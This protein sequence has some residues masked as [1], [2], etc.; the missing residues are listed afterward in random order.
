MKKFIFILIALLS[1]S[2]I[3][4]ARTFALITA[5]SNYGDE[6]DTNATTNGAK[7]FQKILKT[8]TND[9][10]LLTSSNANAEN[11]I[12]KLKAIV[13]RAQKGDRIIFFYNGHGYPGGMACHSSS[14][15]YERLVETL[16]E[17]KASEV[18]VFIDACHSGSAGDEVTAGK[19]WFSGIKSRKGH[20][21]ML[22]SRGDEYSWAAGWLNK[23]F[24]TQ[25]LLTGYRGKSDTNHDR[26]ITV[27]E[28]FKHIHKDV[29]RRSEGEQH[30]VMI[31]P[32]SMYDVELIRYNDDNTVS[33]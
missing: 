10:S 28:L 11:I 32:K 3:S 1:V 5:V 19:N 26:A 31:A 27:M 17:T 33:E 25:A 20:V 8:Q 21:Y 7:A 24:F 6:S 14:L 15:P 12:E 13:N 18:I 16:N 9:V 22:S 2:F 23:S 4:E 30:P 29:V